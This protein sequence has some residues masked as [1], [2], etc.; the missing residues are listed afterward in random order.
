MHGNGVISSGLTFLSGCFLIFILFSSPGCTE[1]QTPKPKGYFRID[2]PEKKYTSYDAP[3]CPF[4]FDLPVYATVEN[5]RDSMAQPCWKYVKYPQFDAEIFLSYKSVDGNIETYLEDARTLAYKHTVKAESIDETLV[6][7]KHG[8]SGMIYD[9]GGNAASAVQ[10]YATDST[11][12][13][14][15]GALYFN[16]APQ[17]DSLAPV[18]RFLR[19]DIVRMITTLKWK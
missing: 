1:S 7:T 9:I 18:I 13:F 11:R 5:Y 15:R 3:S 16:V 19:E 10:F 12:H 2:L 6:E 4:Q 8:V 14:L 17:P